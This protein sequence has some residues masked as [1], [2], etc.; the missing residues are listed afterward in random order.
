MAKQQTPAEDGSE[1]K[2][3]VRLTND[4]PAM[5]LKPSINTFI[6]LLEDKFGSSLRLNEMTG[7]PELYDH[8]QDNGANGRTFMMRKCGFGFRKNMDC[9]TKKCSGTLSRFISVSIR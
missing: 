1:N 4:K 6:G 8:V 2:S 5:D 7:K 9:I 3:T